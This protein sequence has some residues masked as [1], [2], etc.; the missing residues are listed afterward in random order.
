MILYTLGL[1]VGNSPSHAYLRSRNSEG[2]SLLWGAK[3][4]L[5]NT[6]SVYCGFFIPSRLGH[7]LND[8]PS[9]FSGASKRHPTNSV[10]LHANV[11]PLRRPWKLK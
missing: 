8:P 1:A 7:K 10:H 3:S 5:I 9:L 2:A 6:Q 11:M 4:E